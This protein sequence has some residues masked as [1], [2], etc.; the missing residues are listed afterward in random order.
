MRA[1][2]ERTECA[3]AACIEQRDNYLR[4]CAF[5]TDSFWEDVGSERRITLTNYMGDSEKLHSNWYSKPDYFSAL[6]FIA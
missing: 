2:C 6:K 1:I 5:N 3:F 4:D